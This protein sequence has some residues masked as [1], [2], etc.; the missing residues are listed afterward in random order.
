[1]LL[2]K[3]M[4]FKDVN[5]YGGK[6]NKERIIVMVCVNM[7]GIDKFFLLV[8]GRVL[9]FRCFKYVKFFFVEYYLNKKVWMIL[10]IFIEWVKKLEK[11]MFRK[12]RKIALIVDNCLVYSKIVGFKV[13]EFVFLFSNIILKI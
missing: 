2:D 6:K 8:I 9:N 3:I 1:M 13:V 12:K 7:S 4:E 5:C 11:K 10:E